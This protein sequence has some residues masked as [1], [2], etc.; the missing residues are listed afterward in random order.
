MEDTRRITLL[1]L[2]VNFQTHADANPHKVTSDRLNRV[3][4]KYC[5][6]FLMGVIDTKGTNG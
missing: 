2:I 1:N 5:A 3:R 4:V 6:R